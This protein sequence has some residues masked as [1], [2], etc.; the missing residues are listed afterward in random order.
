MLTVILRQLESADFADSNV[1][2]RGKHARFLGLSLKT[3]EMNIQPVNCLKTQR[4]CE[5]FAK[6]WGKNMIWFWTPKFKIDR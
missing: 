4:Q 2:R 3:Y 6:K 1:I 5:T